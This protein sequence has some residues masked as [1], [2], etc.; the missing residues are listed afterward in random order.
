MKTKEKIQEG[1]DGYK[2]MSHVYG[3]VNRSANHLYDAYREL[4]HA[5][6]HCDN[7]ELRKRLE[8]IKEKLG[9]DKEVAGYVDNTV[10]TVIALMQDA[11][12]DLKIS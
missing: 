5:I 11:L 10:P 8:G 6:Q 2:R 4:E 12:S 3:I 7:P 9:C 1:L